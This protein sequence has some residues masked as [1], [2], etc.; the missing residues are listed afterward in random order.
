MKFI[1]NIHRRDKRFDSEIMEKN[2]Y[3][4]IKIYNTYICGLKSWKNLLCVKLHGP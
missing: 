4:Y 2:L 3:N 1:E